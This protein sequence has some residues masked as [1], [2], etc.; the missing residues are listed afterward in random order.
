[1]NKKASL[2]FFLIV[3]NV[4]IYTGCNRNKPLQGETTV[5]NLKT[6]GNP[7]ITEGSADPSVR[8]FDDR[9]YIYPSHDFLP[10][11]EFWIMK[12]WKVYS[13]EDLVNFTD[14]G[15]ILEGVEVS[16]AVVPDHC[17][18]PD[19]IEKNGKYYFYF[20]MSDKTGIWKGRIG[21]GVADKPYGPFRDALGYPLV[22]DYDRPA[23]FEGGHYN[24]DP[25]VFIDDDGRSYLFWGN[26]V[27]FMAELNE[28]MVSLKS[29]II[30]INIENHLGYREGPFV[31]KRK[32]IYYLLYSRMGSSGFDVL[33][34]ATSTQIGGPYKFKGTIVGHGR[35]GNEHGSVFQYKGQWYV[36]YHDLFPTDKYRKTCI[37]IIHYREDGEIVRILPT[38]KGVGWYDGSEKIEAENYFEK[39]GGIEY[40]DHDTTGFYIE[41][42]EIGSWIKFPNVK[43][44]FDYQNRF[45]ACVASGSEGGTIGI[46]LD[47]LTGG[48]AGEL[49]IGNT[50]GWDSW[51]I[52][53]TVLVSFSGTKDIYLV[54]QGKEEELFNL[55]WFRFE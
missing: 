30:H 14:H 25:A 34:Y 33:D 42:M 24:I 4:F 20:P 21:V 50:G 11:N 23:D 41:C 43:M 52:M 10:D 39:S 17:W 27:C 46:M 38:R 49:R 53:D 28:D 29:E 12:D 26:G 15:I 13:S 22:Y 9:V 40:K 35:K 47:S 7:V 32:D 5:S 36:A 3:C 51:W 1:M 18:A 6:G 8:V 48:K 19:C 55:D 2:L 16:W 54:F 31:W 45:S 44:G 37:D